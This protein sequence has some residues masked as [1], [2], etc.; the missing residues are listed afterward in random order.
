MCVP[1]QRSGQRL[2]G[3]MIVQGGEAQ[4]RGAV[5]LDLHRP[6]HQHQL[7]HAEA[8][9]PK[10]ERIGWIPRVG[11]ESRGKKDAQEANFEQKDVP[12]KRKKGLSDVEHA[13]V[14]GEERGPKPT[15]T[16]TPGE[17]RQPHR[18]RRQSRASKT[19]PLRRAVDGHA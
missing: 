12:L 9:E 6:T 19:N 3:K 4:P 8:E 1:S 16:T 13:E 11:T 14:K 5:R 17:N 7:E 15:Q 10:D 18:G 2:R